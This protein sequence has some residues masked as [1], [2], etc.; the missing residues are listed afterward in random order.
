ML[1][2]EAEF[3][4]PVST[5]EVRP[6]RGKTAGNSLAGGVLPGKPSSAPVIG[7]ENRY[8]EPALSA[9]LHPS[10]WMG[11]RSGKCGFTVFCIEKT[12]AIDIFDGENESRSLHDPEILGLSF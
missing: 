11:D 4:L 12:S 3:A 5:G 8:Y 9:I 10:A 7:A 6:P 1:T 2:P